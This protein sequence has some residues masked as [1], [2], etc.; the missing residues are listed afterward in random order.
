MRQGITHSDGCT[1]NCMR[2]RVNT[3]DKNDGNPQDKAITDTYENKF[4]IPLNFEMLDSAMPCY[5]SGLG[6]R[7]CYKITFNNYGRVIQST[8]P[9]PDAEYEISDISLEYDIVSHPDLA[10]LIKLEYKSMVLFHDRI[11]R[12]R[13]IL[14]NKSN[15]MWNWSFITPCK[16]LK[17]ILVLIEADKLYDRDKS[18]FYN[19]KIQKVSV[20]VEGNP[21]HLFA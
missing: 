13:Q 4:I 2:L 21:N 14:V 12:H 5:Q 11:L 8:G 17:G 6:N 15:T 19:P 9:S 1:V 7:L 10:S 18:K 16:S 20:V 3:K